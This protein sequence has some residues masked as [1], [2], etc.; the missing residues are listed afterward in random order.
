[1][2]ILFREYFKYLT[3]I[4][5]GTFFL[6]LDLINTNIKSNGYIII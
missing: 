1:M 6:L 4:I 2:T 3:K 5:V